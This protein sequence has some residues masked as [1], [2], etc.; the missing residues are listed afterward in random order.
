MK[1]ITCGYCC[2]WLSLIVLNACGNPNVP[3]DAD[4]RQA[5]DSISS[6]QIRVARAELDTLC[7]QRHATELPRLVDSIKRVRL[8]EIQEQLKTVPK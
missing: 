1:P 4:T 3:L 6:E 2:L 5:I 7:Q 8:R